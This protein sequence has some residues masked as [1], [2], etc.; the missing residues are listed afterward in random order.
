[1]FSADS[2]PKVATTRSKK[3]SAA[4][5]NRSQICEGVEAKKPRRENC[6]FEAANQ[7]IASSNAC[8]NLMCSAVN[9]TETSSSNGGA[10]PESKPE[11]QEA[12]NDD[13]K[14]NEKKPRGLID[15]RDLPNILSIGRILKDNEISG[16]IRTACKVACQRLMGNSGRSNDKLRHHQTTEYLGRGTAIIIV[17]AGADQPNGGTDNS[18]SEKKTGEAKNDEGTANNEQ[19]G[20]D[21]NNIK[22]SASDVIEAEANRNEDIRNEASGKCAKENEKLTINEGRDS[23][24]Q[25]S[26][27]ERNDQLKGREMVTNVDGEIREAKECYVYVENI[28]LSKESDEEITTSETKGKNEIKNEIPRKKEE[29]QSKLANDVEEN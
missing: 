22:V 8:T 28:D 13:P 17:N 7:L 29:I 27:D 5:P 11:N 21:A 1:M 14:T 26:K 6:G 24:V 4:I 9:G 12:K 10:K 25:R 19:V 18:S 16:E 2:S 3:D 20:E 23:Q 15:G